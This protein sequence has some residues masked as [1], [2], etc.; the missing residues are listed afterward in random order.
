MDTIHCKIGRQ[1]QRE[2]FQVSLLLLGRDCRGPGTATHIAINLG[3]GTLTLLQNI[4]PAY[5]DVRPVFCAFCCCCTCGNEVVFSVSCNVACFLSGLLRRLEEAFPISLAE[6]D[7]VA[8]LHTQVPGLRLCK[9]S[10]AILGVLRPRLLPQRHSQSRC[11]CFSL[12]ICWSLM[13]VMVMGRR[14]MYCEYSIDY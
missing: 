9:T 5:L 6:L 4:E 14:H 13:T 10:L 7:Y 11:T 2:A 12:Q 8:V 1:L 3:S